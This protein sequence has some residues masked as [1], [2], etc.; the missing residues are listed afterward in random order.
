[1]GKKKKFLEPY[2][3]RKYTVCSNAVLVLN[4]VVSAAATK[5]LRVYFAFG[6]VKICKTSLQVYVDSNATGRLLT[7]YSAFVKYWKKKKK[8]GI[9]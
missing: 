9:Q 6:V 1:M 8:M 5:F 3:K 2:G 7:I 4:M